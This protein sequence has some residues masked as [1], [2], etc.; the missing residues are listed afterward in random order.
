MIAMYNIVLAASIV[1]LWVIFFSPYSGN[2]IQGY[3][4]RYTPKVKVKFL[5]Y[6]IT[7]IDVNLICYLFN[8][9]T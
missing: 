1:N 6:N 5:H 3:I 9:V 2:V 7:K 8:T 4:S